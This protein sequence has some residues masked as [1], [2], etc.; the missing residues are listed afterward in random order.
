M[1]IAGTLMV[2]SDSNTL[3]RSRQSVGTPNIRARDS[4]RAVGTVPVTV[5]ITNGCCTKRSPPVWKSTTKSA[6]S[7]Q[8][9]MYLSAMRSVAKRAWPEKASP[10]SMRSS[11]EGL[12]RRMAWK[13]GGLATGMRMTRPD[14]VAGSRAFAT[15]CIASAPPTSSPCP[16]EMSH[17]TGPCVLPATTMTGAST[18]DPSAYSINGSLPRVTSPGRTSAVPTRSGQ[19]AP[20]AGAIEAEDQRSKSGDENSKG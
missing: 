14:I 7:F 10:K 2:M 5:K 4:M 6:C 9:T 19:V 20:Q 15:R 11:G 12:T 1:P 3:S 17:A 16:Q 18:S 13:A 8:R